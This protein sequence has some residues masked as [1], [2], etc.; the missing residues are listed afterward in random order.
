MQTSVDRAISA[1]RNHTDCVSI[2]GAGLDD[3]NTKRL[4]AALANSD[5]L[6]ELN[7]SCNKYGHGDRDRDFLFSVCFDAGYQMRVARQLAYC[8]SPANHCV[9][10]TSAT[11]TWTRMVPVLARRLCACQ[12]DPCQV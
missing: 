8:S 4:I 3:A 10:L 6:L 11:T 7:L 2:V 9:I 12:A 5:V 1:V